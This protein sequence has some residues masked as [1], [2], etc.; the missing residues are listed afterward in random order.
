MRS[1]NMQF[2]GA[3]AGVGST[4]GNGHSRPTWRQI[5]CPKEGCGAP[6]HSMCRRRISESYN[7]TQSG[8][9]TGEGRWQTLKHPHP[10]RKRAAR[11]ETS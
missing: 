5:A 3:L 11:E 6:P 10:E 1:H 9:H 4:F 2:A 8:G 7:T